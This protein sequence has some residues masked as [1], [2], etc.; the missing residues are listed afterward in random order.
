VLLP[1]NNRVCYLPDDD[2]SRAAKAAFAGPTGRPEMMAGWQGNIAN[3]V[4][5]NYDLFGVDR[6]SQFI[7]VFAV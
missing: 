1:V 5:G 2:V 3:L 7:R 6:K 4:R